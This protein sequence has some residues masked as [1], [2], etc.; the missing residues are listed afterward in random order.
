MKLLHSRTWLTVLWVCGFCIAM[1]ELFYLRWVVEIGPD[2]SSKLF[3][4]VVAQYTPYLGAVL[5]FHFASTAILRRKRVLAV[6]F[7]SAMITSCIWNL[8]TI[9]PI[10]RACFDYNLTDN[11]LND[12][13]AFVPK[14]AW[15]VA[16]SI[17]VFFGKSQEGQK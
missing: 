3:D 6:T 16:P 17:G 5:G 12:I 15:L 10:L 7:W 8:V 14:L 4:L 11:A 1:F 9:I 2:A 13:K